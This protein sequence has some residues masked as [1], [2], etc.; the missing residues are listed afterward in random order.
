MSELADTVSL[1]EAT[2]EQLRATL[3]EAKVVANRLSENSRNTVLLLEAGPTDD[4]LF[5]VKVRCQST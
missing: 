5:L 3:A 1:A 2:T 4:N